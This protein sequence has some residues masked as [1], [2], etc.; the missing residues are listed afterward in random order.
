M[1]YRIIEDKCI[2]CGACYDACGVG[3]IVDT[4]PPTITEACI[5]CGSCVPL[6]AAGAI[7]MKD[8]AVYVGEKTVQ[9]FFVGDKPV[10][11][12]YVGSKKIYG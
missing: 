2:S 10:Q 11:A 9:G 5:G 1:K 4:A 8:T 3:A 7:E 6:C 12:L